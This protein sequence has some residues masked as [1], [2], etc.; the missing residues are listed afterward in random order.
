MGSKFWVTFHFYYE[1]I[2]P[3]SFAQYLGESI[4]NW[5]S[6]VIVSFK[7]WS[8]FFELYWFCLISSKLFLNSGSR[9][10][11]FSIHF[12]IVPKICDEEVFREIV[13]FRWIEFSRLDFPKSLKHRKTF[14]IWPL[15]KK[16]TLIFESVRWQVRSN[17][18]EWQSYNYLVQSLKFRMGPVIMV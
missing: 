5:L 3:N 2:T 10:T 1:K 8:S 7:A 13:N 18:K 15:T 9:F 11:C 16:L 14:K 12:V 4:T 6:S 17:Q